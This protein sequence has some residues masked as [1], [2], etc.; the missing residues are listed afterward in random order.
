MLH[1]GLAKAEL[2]GVVPRREQRVGA[3]PQQNDNQGEVLLSHRQVQRRHFIRAKIV[4]MRPILEQQLDNGR[5]TLG[6]GFLE[7]I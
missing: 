6:N 1:L 7:I 4:N 3:V 2:V 5:V